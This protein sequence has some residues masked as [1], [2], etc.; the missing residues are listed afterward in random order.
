[1]KDLIIILSFILFF[2]I[3]AG[4]FIISAGYFI[5]TKKKKYNFKKGGRN[6]GK[7]Y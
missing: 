4:Y 6:N 7:Y 3:S 1:M 5:I 2:I